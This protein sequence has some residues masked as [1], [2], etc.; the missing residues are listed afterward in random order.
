M[1]AK[2]IVSAILII[3]LPFVIIFGFGALSDFFNQMAS[4]TFQFAYKI[5]GM[6]TSVVPIVA[7]IFWLSFVMR[8]KHPKTRILLSIC[9]LAVSAILIACLIAPFIL[10]VPFH[11][12]FYYNNNFDLYTCKSVRRVLYA[13]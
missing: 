12:L 5:A 2:H 13:C 10:S 1:K 4:R 3:I 9:S 11:F 6:I 8:T 7:Y